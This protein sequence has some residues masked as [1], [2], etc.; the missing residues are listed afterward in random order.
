MHLATRGLRGLPWRPWLTEGP[1]R[2]A[3]AATECTYIPSGQLTSIYMFRWS[4]WGSSVELR[5]SGR[6]VGALNE[7]GTKLLCEKAFIA[8]FTSNLPVSCVS[9]ES[10][11]KSA[12]DKASRGLPYGGRVG[13]GFLKAAV[14]AQTLKYPRVV[15]VF[16][17]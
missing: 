8:I 3:F 15:R 16:T 1:L 13:M 11:R 7:N 9:R 12:S 10:D 4:Y 2:G 6:M 14:T 5:E 17:R